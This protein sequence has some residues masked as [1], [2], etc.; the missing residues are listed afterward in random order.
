MYPEIAFAG[1]SNVGKS[2]LIN[3]LTQRKGLA[4][5]SGTPGKTQLIS[6]FIINDEWYLVD[7]PGYGYAKRSKSDRSQW[8]K[9]VRSYLTGRPSLVHVFILLDAR[10][11]P[12]D[13]DLRFMEWLARHQIPF[14]LVFTKADK[15]T[16]NRLKN[17]IDDYKE[18]LLQSWDGLPLAI[19][20]SAQTQMGRE[21][22]LEFITEENKEFRPPKIDPKT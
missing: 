10:L 2:S 14:V 3:M 7:L 17:S 1:R 15:L 19:I 6:H 20:S 4:K 5:T 16:K 13:N 11:A 12:Q 21:D 8:E 9:M 18:E 22:I